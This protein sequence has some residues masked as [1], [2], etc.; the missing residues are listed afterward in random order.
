MT[1]VH[2]KD[3][4][5]IALD[6]AMAT[7]AKLSIGTVGPHYIEIDIPE[8]DRR[9]YTPTSD[10]GQGGPIVAEMIEEGFR[11][12]KAD[13]GLGVKYWKV[14]PGDRL[15]NAY[16]KTPLEAA[17]RCRVLTKLGEAVDVPDTL[18]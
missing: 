14:E 4:S 2:T 17:V 1:S 6:W 18:L 10:W 7:C 15:I 11:I 13:F 5:R 9:V 8:G 12:E 16:G 3:L